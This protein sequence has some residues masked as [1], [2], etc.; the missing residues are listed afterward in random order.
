MTFQL[1]PLHRLHHKLAADEIIQTMQYF[2]HAEFLSAE[3]E[4]EL[5]L[6]SGVKVTKKTGSIKI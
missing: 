5:L 3:F 4:I 1:A 2:G 6:L